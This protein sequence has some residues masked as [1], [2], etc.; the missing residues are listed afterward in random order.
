MRRFRRRRRR[1]AALALLPIAT[2]TATTTITSAAAESTG[3]AS[4]AASKRSVRFGGELTL[5]GSFA[6]AGDEAVEIQHQA[7]RSREWRVAGRTTTDA[8][9]IYR[10]TVKP[11]QSG[12]WRARLAE[13]PVALAAGEESDDTAASGAL[14]TDSERVKVRSRTRAKV[15]GRN[16]TVGGMARIKGQVKP[17]GAKRDVTVRVGGRS[18]HTTTDR[19]GSFTV[20][21]PA[22]RTGTYKVEVAAEGNR[23]AAGSS[24]SA[25]KVTVYRPAAASW[26][27]PG[28]YGN[29]TA[30][31]G[32]LSPSTLGVAHKTMPCGTKLTLR[33]RGKSVKVRVIDRGPFSGSR[34]FDLTAA[35]KQRLGFPDTGTVLTSK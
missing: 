7:K 27:G 14:E 1:L 19:G 4:I 32:T 28:L 11:R 15:S 10:L 8:N 20:R 13:G 24:D 33:Y 3:D 23:T 31:G 22:R 9:G 35:T 2:L 12:F 17:G 30:C 25:G 34:E 16:L 18:I 5:S 29:G 6:S 21:W 26:Y